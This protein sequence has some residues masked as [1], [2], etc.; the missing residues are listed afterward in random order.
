MS[1]LGRGLHPTHPPSQQSR[2]FVQ[3]YTNTAD[4]VINLRIA[5][6][7]DGTFLWL[8]FWIWKRHQESI[9]SNILSWAFIY[10]ND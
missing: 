6:Q 3:S 8:E 10:L 2:D 1:F 5:V 4:N 7:H 9:R